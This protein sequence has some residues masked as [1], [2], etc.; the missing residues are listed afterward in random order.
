MWSGRIWRIATAAEFEQSSKEAEAI[1]QYAAKIGFRVA[2]KGSG[3]VILKYVGKEN[4][5]EIPS[6]ILNIPVIEIGFQAFSICYNLTSVTIPNSVTS[7]GDYAFS[8]CGL[9]SVTIPNS[10]TSIGDYA[11]SGCTSL[12]SVT[13]ATGSNITDFGNNA[14][15]E[16]NGYSSG[17]ALKTAYATG[18]AGTYTRPKI[19]GY[20]TWTKQ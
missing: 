19:L 10:V 2:K 7:I 3:I 18:K 8:G 9:A 4:V 15:P 17:N 13:F 20:D 16:D 12:A 5:V 1:I 14:F 6:N 11:F